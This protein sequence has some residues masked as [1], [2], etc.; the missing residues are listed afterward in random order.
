M[1]IQTILRLATLSGMMLMALQAGN[2]TAGGDALQ[3]PGS[4]RPMALAEAFVADAGTVDSLSY[5]PAG[6]ASVVGREYSLRLWQKIFSGWTSDL[7]SGMASIALPIKSIGTLGAEFK[8]LKTDSF[9]EIDP[10]GVAVPGS[11]ISVQNFAGTVGIGR[12][13]FN[14]ISA[15][16]NV[17]YVRDSYADYAFDYI[18]VDAG[19]LA[20]TLFPGI[21]YASLGVAARNI[22]VNIVK[23]ASAKSVDLPLTYAAGFKIAVQGNSPHGL[24]LSSE[25]NVITTSV[26]RVAVGAEYSYDSKYFV[27]GGYNYFFDHIGTF[28]VGAGFKLKIKVLKDFQV[29]A[30]YA[31]APLKDQFSQYAQSFSLTFLNSAAE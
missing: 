26:N 25:Y 11:T 28:T 17:K 8:F 3:I 9:G 29:F 7:S 15:G 31:V 13:I 16:A 1:K 23:D 10:L 24:M 27:R 2:L 19:I 22:G 14:H 18:A 4:A 30:N 20:S 12:N 6:L 5:N 21:G